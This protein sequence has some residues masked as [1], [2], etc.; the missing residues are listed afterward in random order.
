MHNNHLD[1]QAVNAQLHNSDCFTRNRRRKPRPA[2]VMDMTVKF[3]NGPFLRSSSPQRRQCVHGRHAASG[4]NRR[5]MFEAHVRAGRLSDTGTQLRRPQ[6]DR[7]R[8]TRLS[9]TCG[10]HSYQPR[11]VVTQR[12]DVNRFSKCEYHTGRRTY[13]AL[14]S[15]SANFI[16]TFK[17][18]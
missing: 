15:V 12:Q 1:R 7:S 2:P 5:P 17:H 10:Y 4:K 11:R 3:P 18:V 9:E 14:A 13:T 8:G 16:L 6:N